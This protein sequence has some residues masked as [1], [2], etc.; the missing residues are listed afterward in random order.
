MSHKSCAHVRIVSK[1]AISTPRDKVC[2]L[3]AKLRKKRKREREKFSNV[4]WPF[5]VKQGLKGAGRKGEKAQAWSWTPAT[6]A[7]V[8]IRQRRVWVWRGY[9]RRAK[10]VWLK[11]LR[12][13][14]F[15]RS[16]T[17]YNTYCTKFLTKWFLG[18]QTGQEAECRPET[19]NRT[20]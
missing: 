19:L 5:L 13:V 4:P 11:R 6:E 9:S 15:I 12:C 17:L 2:A 3:L 14:G 1:R 16:S 20:L 7:S 10:G 18:T 8:L